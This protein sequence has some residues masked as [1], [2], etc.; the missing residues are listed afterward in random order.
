MADR[1]DQRSARGITTYRGHKADTC[2]AAGEPPGRGRSRTALAE[3]H[4]AGDVG[5]GNKIR[6]RRQ[7][8]VDDQVADDHDARSV[9]WSAALALP[10]AI[11]YGPG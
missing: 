8:D 1:R 5:S 11:E 10:H 2:A 6:G 9:M 4:A 3:H 7:D